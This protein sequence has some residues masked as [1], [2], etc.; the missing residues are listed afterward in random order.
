MPQRDCNRSARYKC[1]FNERGT[2][3]AAESRWKWHSDKLKHIAAKQ[4][5]CVPYRNAVLALPVHITERFLRDA[6]E[7]SFPGIVDPTC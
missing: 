4:I 1:Q 2:A 5:A 6:V 7:A 3:N